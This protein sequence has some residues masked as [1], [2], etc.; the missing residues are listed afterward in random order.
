MQDHGHLT[1]HLLQQELTR[2]REIKG[3]L[4]LVICVHL[5]PADENEIKSE[6]SAVADSLGLPIQLAYEGM[7]VQL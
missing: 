4:P 6:I 3:Y 7:Q 2:F 5:N 1:P